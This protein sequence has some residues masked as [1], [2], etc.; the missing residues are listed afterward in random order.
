M[1]TATAPAGSGHARHAQ[2]AAAQLPATLA[3]C[4]MDQQELEALVAAARQGEPVLAR[5][6]QL[7]ATVRALLAEIEEVGRGEA[8][9][10]AQAARQHRLLLAFRAARNAAA[11]GG[12]PAVAA[13]LHEGLLDAVRTTLAL[14]SDATIA[15]DWQLPA[16]VAQA[17][18]NLCTA[19]SDGAAAAWGA[20]FPLQLT[21]LAHV[22]AGGPGGA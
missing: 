1:T 15:L 20:L 18:A 3:A 10:A 19:C 8:A 4:T 12:P 17:L 11:T 6:P 5:L 16:A 13:L 22:N 9:Q 7:L 2:P 14:V 21:I